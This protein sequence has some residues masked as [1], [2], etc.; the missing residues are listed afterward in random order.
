MLSKI[1]I[2]TGMF[3]QYDTTLME[4]LNSSVFNLKNVFKF[5][6]SEIQEI[7]DG[8]EKYEEMKI[9]FTDKQIKE[10]IL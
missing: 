8:G 2:P 1:S 7:L 10:I 4:P 6:E 5:C 9:Q 3:T